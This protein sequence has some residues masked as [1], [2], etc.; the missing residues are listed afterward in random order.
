MLLFNR[1]SSG[2]L[3][4]SSS[5]ILLLVVLCS[6]ARLFVMVSG[7]QL[8]FEIVRHDTF[9]NSSVTELDDKTNK[10]FRDLY[11]RS[12]GR[13]VKTFN[14][15]ITNNSNVT[16]GATAD[17][18]IVMN[19][20]KI[21]HNLMKLNIDL[22]ANHTDKQAASFLKL[23]DFL[24]DCELRI[25]EN[26]HPLFNYY[27]RPGKG[28]INLLPKSYISNVRILN[29]SNEESAAITNKSLLT[30]H[31]H[32]NYDESG[33]NNSKISVTVVNANITNNN[34]NNNS[35]SP[36][37]LLKI[38]KILSSLMD[39]ETLMLIILAI[40]LLICLV[41]AIMIKRRDKRRMRLFLANAREDINSDNDNQYDDCRRRRW[42]KLPPVVVK[43]MGIELPVISS[44]SGSGSGPQR[45]PQN[46]SNTNT[47]TTQNNDTNEREQLMGNGEQPSRPSANAPMADWGPIVFIKKYR[48]TSYDDDRSKLFI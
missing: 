42:S 34:N 4:Q 47:V 31:H 22:I 36:L 41:I 18:T 37:F 11:N 24:I 14:S 25:R 20:T 28:L 38:Q 15:I 17:S 43:Q 29:I 35:E 13:D 5:S 32:H 3:V 45:S 21:E 7:L 9:S 27:H 12:V 16:C 19:Q 10:I 30:C 44:S 8:E 40:W 26:N 46:T 23:F 6:A 39:L 1:K 48:E 2:Q 33:E